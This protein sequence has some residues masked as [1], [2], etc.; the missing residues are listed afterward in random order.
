MSARRKKEPD[1]STLLRFIAEHESLAVTLDEFPDLSEDQLRAV[2][3]EAADA[4]HTN[5]L[6]GR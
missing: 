3:A 6:P 4:V 5:A 2:L 1:L